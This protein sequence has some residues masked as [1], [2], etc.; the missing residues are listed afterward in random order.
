[1]PENK[2][3]FI[4]KKAGLRNASELSG[5]ESPGFEKQPAR[6][7]LEEQFICSMESTTE[8][9]PPLTILYVIPS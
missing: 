2:K 5:E 1:M 9:K 7:Y 4:I 3:I 6:E 8:N